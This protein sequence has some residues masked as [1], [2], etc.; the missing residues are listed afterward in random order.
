[1]SIL[2]ILL[3]W[4]SPLSA[5]EAP[6]EAPAQS[7][8]TNGPTPMDMPEALAKAMLM[9]ESGGISKD[10]KTNV[11]ALFLN[12]SFRAL[13]I[14]DG[15]QRS[16][17]YRPG[18]LQADGLYMLP[19]TMRTDGRLHSIFKYYFSF[20]KDANEGASA[21]LVRWEE[22]NFISRQISRYATFQELERGIGFFQSIQPL[23]AKEQALAPEAPAPTVQTAE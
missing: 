10:Y 20:D 14:S 1:M 6:A 13:R 18:E 15:S 11:G 17:A 3:L 7:Q 19:I 2:L 9:I 23:P 8:E 5:Q 12:K 22:I 4:V 21:Y 16:F